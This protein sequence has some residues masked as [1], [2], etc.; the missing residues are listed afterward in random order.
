LHPLREQIWTVPPSAK[1]KGTIGAPHS[2]HE[3]VLASDLHGAA[4][5]IEN[6]VVPLERTV[7][8]L[9]IEMIRTNF[10]SLRSKE[11]PQLTLAD[12]L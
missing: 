5:P 12:Y 11:A 7:A 8:D 9:Q 10:D 3:R 2:S 4:R 1:P 6:P